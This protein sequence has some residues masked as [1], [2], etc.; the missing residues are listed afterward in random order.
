[1]AFDKND[2]LNE[3][4]QHYMTNTNVMGAFVHDESPIDANML[5]KAFNDANISS[6]SRDDFKF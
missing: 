3:K 2:Q 5:P 6:E 4:S 1:M